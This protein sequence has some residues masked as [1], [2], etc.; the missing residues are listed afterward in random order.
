MQ[1]SISLSR[2]ELYLQ[3]DDTRPIMGSNESKKSTTMIMKSIQPTPLDV[4][5]LFSCQIN[6]L[7]VLLLLV[8]SLIYSRPGFLISYSGYLQEI[9]HHSNEMI[10]K[11]THKDIVTMAWT[12]FLV[13]VAGAFTPVLHLLCDDWIST[14]GLET[15]RSFHMRNKSDQCNSTKTFFNIL[16]EKLKI[17][18]V[19]R[20]S[21]TTWKDTQIASREKEQEHKF[22]Q[23][24]DNCGALCTTDFFDEFED[25]SVKSLKIDILVENPK[26]DRTNVF[27]APIN[28]NITTNHSSPCH[29]VEEASDIKPS[30]SRNTFKFDDLMELKD[31]L[32]YL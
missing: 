21:T 19:N 6:Y 13:A 32:H 23:N 29:G 2:S 4:S 25:T 24:I 7:V 28:D 27:H 22:V 20:S 3:D 26:N 14:L 11:T 1:P 10:S 18:N 17:C 5:T 16:I 8:P 15:L 31:D 12:H 30:N 9:I